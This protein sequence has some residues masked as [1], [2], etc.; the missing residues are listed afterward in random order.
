MRCQSPFASFVDLELDQIQDGQL[1][2]S[3][4]VLKSLSMAGD[5][6]LGA[7]VEG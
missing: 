4:W 1:R 3:N 2:V 7:A 6:S 5:L